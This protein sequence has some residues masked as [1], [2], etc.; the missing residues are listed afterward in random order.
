[1]AQVFDLPLEKVW[2]KNRRPQVVQARSLL[3][4][5]AAKKLGMSMTEIAN[6]LGQ[7]QPAVS[8]AARRGENIA[9]QRGYSLF[10]E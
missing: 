6:R 1:V 9:T 5:W 2:E 4:Y 3:C 10:D 8:I 7:T